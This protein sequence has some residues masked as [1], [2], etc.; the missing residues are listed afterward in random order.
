[1]TKDYKWRT[2][3]TSGEGTTTRYVDGNTG[4]DLFG[5]GTRANPYRTLGRAYRVSDT[6]PTTIICRGCFSEMLVDGNHACSINADYYGAA[7]FDGREQFLIYGFRHKNMIFRDTCIGN[8]DMVLFNSLGSGSLAGVG[9][10]FDADYVGFANFVYGVA[11]S[12]NL[13]HKVALYMGTIGGNTACKYLGFSRV[14]NH[15]SYP[16]QLGGYQSGVV[17][18]NSTVYG[19]EDIS[20]RCKTGSIYYSKIIISSIFAKFAM[21]ANDVKFEFRQCLFAADVKWYYL[22]GTKGESGAQEI[23]I[24]GN[25]SQAKIESLQTQLTAIY[26]ANNIEES[27][28]HMPTFV[29]CIFSDQTSEELFNNPE[30]GDLTLRV[31]SEA[32]TSEYEYIG[33]FPP[34][35]NIPIL[36]D[37]S[38]IAETW[39]ETTCSGC[40]SVTNNAICLDDSN[41]SMSGEIMSKVIQVDTSHNPLNGLYAL[42]QNRFADH[43]AYLNGIDTVGNKQYM[44]GESLPIGRYVVKGSILYRDVNIDNDMILVVSE[45]NTNFADE[46]ENSFV[47][48]IIEP[49]IIDVIYVR[50][51]GGIYAKCVQTELLQRGATYINSGNSNITYRNRE[52]APGESFVA[53]GDDYWSGPAGYEIG[54]LFNDTRVPDSDWVPAQIF[55]EYFALKENGAIKLDEDNIPIG[56]GNY[57]AWQTAANGG[58]KGYFPKAIMNQQ[59]VQFKIVIKRYDR[60]SA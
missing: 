35:I 15:S 43:Y 44:A 47:C 1:M 25:D 21:I 4:S 51:R 31:G 19:V 38:G 10:A 9:S 42:T 17:L 12:P 24:D 37:S 48:P 53:M 59:F 55:G 60:A 49:N 39:D 8:S 28:R 33:A 50:C 22:S 5:T 16:I 30:D 52:I 32:I 58:Y 6:K 2:A 13:M 45:E 40:I 14:K 20:H 27:S 23:V 29:D 34:A 36:S 57:L 11:G 46:I 41:T 56:S 18:Q 54:I 7:V 3:V 26:D